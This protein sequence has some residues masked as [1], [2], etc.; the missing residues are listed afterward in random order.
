[1]KTPALSALVVLTICLAP[2]PALADD[3]APGLVWRVENPFPLVKNPKHV[4]YLTR[5]LDAMERQQDFA[6]Y[7]EAVLSAYQHTQWDSTQQRYARDYIHQPRTA[8]MVRLNSLTDAT[9]TWKGL[10]FTPAGPCQHEQ[11]VEID[12]ARPDNLQVFVEQGEEVS[13]FTY[14]VQPNERLI[15]GLGD[16]FS[17][18]EGNPDRPFRWRPEQLST[19]AARGLRRDWAFKAIDIQDDDKADWQDVSCHRSLYSWQFLYALK[20]STRDPHTLVKFASFACSG[21]EIYDGLLVRQELSQVDGK[22]TYKAPDSQLNEAVGLLCSEPPQREVEGTHEQRR[23]GIQHEV[24]VSRC[25]AGKLKAPDEVLLTIGGND[26]AFSGLI[27]W[28][29]FPERG[30]N[31]VTTLFGVS[32]V[33]RALTPKSKM[34]CP[35]HNSLNDTRCGDIFSAEK[36]FADNWLGQNI[37]LSHRLINQYLQPAR[38]L[39]LN[40]PSPTRDESGAVCDIGPSTTASRAL[41]N[42]LFRVLDEELWDSLVAP[43]YDRYTVGPLAV[44]VKEV[45]RQTVDPLQRTILAS[46]GGQVQTLD[47]S[48]PFRT[49][50]FCARSGRYDLELPTTYKQTPAGYWWPY[51][52]WQT[53][54]W[55]STARW[56]RTPNDA[57]L[58]QYADSRF[59]REAWQYGMFHP[60]HLGHFSMYWSLMQLR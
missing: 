32:Q 6:L 52:P 25:P 26:V 54:P 4:E 39:Q 28:T 5:G 33:N 30:Y 11:R 15:I 47:I 19:K 29:A 3:P 35:R 44:K 56:F 21:A 51:K 50:G 59:S 34:A 46:A 53:E 1:M 24:T 41:K 7:S 2:T 60:N 42:E 27:A 36:A 20:Q 37:R 17:S 16:S 49:H 45:E 23:T 48:A 14:S 58:T 18:G 22:R 31:P 8:V 38:L 55:A 40:Y 9:C 13:R 43:W 12:T 57:L 10:T